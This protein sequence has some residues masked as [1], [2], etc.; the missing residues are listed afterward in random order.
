MSDDLTSGYPARAAKLD[1]G[2][3]RTDAQGNVHQ[4]SAPIQGPQGGRG[5]EGEAERRAHL[6][7]WYALL[8]LYTSAYALFR[9]PRPT[10]APRSRGPRSRRCA[11]SLLE[12]GAAAPCQSDEAARA[13]GCS[14]RRPADPTGYGCLS[15]SESDRPRRHDTAARRFRRAET[16]PRFRSCCHRR[17]REGERTLSRAAPCRSFERMS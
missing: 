13:G 2:K 1:S 4:E 7:A 5:R 15:R 16:D 10:I 14:A 3:P 9:A 12:P 11:P 17:R 8:L 6:F